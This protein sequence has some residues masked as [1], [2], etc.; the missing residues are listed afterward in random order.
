MRQDEKRDGTNA[1]GEKS[2]ELKGNSLYRKMQ[3]VHNDNKALR[4]KMV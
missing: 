4:E 1:K 3:S 2:T